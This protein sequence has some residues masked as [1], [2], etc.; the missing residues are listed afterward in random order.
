[1]LQF[2]P[3]DCVVLEG[4]AIQYFTCCSYL[5]LLLFFA[6]WFSSPGVNVSWPNPLPEMN[7]TWTEELVTDLRLRM[8]KAKTIVP[9]CFQVWSLFPLLSDEVLLY[10]SFLAILYHIYHIVHSGNISSNILPLA[11]D[12]INRRIYNVQTV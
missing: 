7:I 11:E 9:V 8:D 2:D 10:H 3:T 6:F 4:F 5:L 12:P 1:M